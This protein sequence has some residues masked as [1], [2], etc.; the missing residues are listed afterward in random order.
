MATF[1]LQDSERVLSNILQTTNDKLRRVAYFAIA[2]YYTRYIFSQAKIVE[3]KVEDIMFFKLKT[4]RILNYLV[5]IA[6]FNKEDLNSIIRSLLNSKL[7]RLSNP[8]NKSLDMSETLGWK[9]LNDVLGVS[10]IYSID[11]I[12]SINQNFPTYCAAYEAFGRLMSSGLMD[13]RIGCPSE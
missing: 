10:S 2:E 6:I 7:E 13:E 4:E 8:I 3:G 5:E 9:C 12:F 1:I 11:D